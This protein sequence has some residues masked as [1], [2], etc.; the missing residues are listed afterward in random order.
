MFRD[1][2][3]NYKNYEVKEE[4]YKI[5]LDANENLNP[6]DEGLKKKILNT[7]AENVDRICFYPEN[8]SDTLREELAKFY[9]LNKENFIV[10][11][12]SDQ[13]IQIIMQAVCEKNDAILVLNPSFV[14]YRITA[15]ILDIEVKQV[16]FNLEWKVD[17]KD[18]INIAQEDD[19]IK[20]V[21]LDTPNNPTGILLNK[22]DISRAAE[23]LKNKILVVDAAYAEFCPC[24]YVDLVGRHE[25]VIVLKTFS[26]IGFAGIRCGYAVSSKHIIDNLHKVKPP[27]NVSFYTQMIA[28]EVLKNFDLVKPNIQKTVEDR[29]KLK[30]DFRALGFNVLDGYGNFLSIVGEG[31]D[32]IQIFLRSKGIAVRYFT[33]DKGTGLLRITVGTKEQNEELLKALK[34]WR[35]LKDEG[36]DG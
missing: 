16:P 22:E 18:I 35:G 33:L 26:K 23:T 12:G 34:E 15:G 9:G 24:D 17:V 7:L 25:N 29:E 6:M 32:D 2:L 11:N 1:K 19:R 4:N 8:N 28:A 30:G 27:Y 31:L 13:L 36:Q 21:F 20:A 10:G 5:K 3:K 14:M